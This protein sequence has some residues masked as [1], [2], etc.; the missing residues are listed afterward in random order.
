MKELQK[1][2]QS[3]RISYEVLECSM[4]LTFDQ[5]SNCGF[6]CA[7]CFSQYQ[8]WLSHNRGKEYDAN[9]V[10]AVD[11]E[12]VKKI[13]RLEK[14][15]PYSQY[16]KDKMTLQW[17]GL[18]DPFCP[19]EKR[20]GVG[21]ELLKFFN[22]I[23]YP[24]SFSSKSDLILRDE[25]Y[26]NEFKKAG[27]RWHYKA[28]ITT[29]NPEIARE[30]ERGVP[31]PD[32]RFEVLKTLSTVGT[33][34]T[35]RLR[36]F[37]LGISDK[38]LEDLIRKAKDAGCQSATMEFFCLEV[39]SKNRERTRKNY[40]IISKHCGFDVV[41]LY[42]TY[43]DKRTGLIRLDPKIKKKYIN[44]FIRLCE[45]YGLK[46]FSSD[47]DFKHKCQGGSCCGLLDGNKKMPYC[48]FQYVWLLQLAKKKGFITLDDA[49]NC[50]DN[51]EWRKKMKLEGTLNLKKMEVLRK[52]S[53]YDYFIKSW[54]DLTSSKNP[55]REFGGVLKPRGKD[56]DGNIIYF[57]D[58][59]KEK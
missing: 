6:R 39:R 10:R 3:P 50:G 19:F 33:Q 34:T 41:Q 49:I 28:S 15:M 1:T 31:P 23:E 47:S 24:I 54:N 18:A 53:L 42:M 58:Y 29:T 59:E 46:W 9:V 52:M 16:I 37:I 43:N 25:R 20:Y 51:L 11:V 45:K 2:Y 57:Y 36:P 38:T 21:L 55:S 5:Y 26:L 35:L 17:G 8:K 44:E 12:K 7:Y 4:P 13:F 22:E 27:D 56:K 30:I 48:K 40:E 14:E 32:Q